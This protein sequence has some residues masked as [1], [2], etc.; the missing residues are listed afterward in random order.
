MDLTNKVKKQKVLNTG[1]ASSLVAAVTTSETNAATKP[2]A[3]GKIKVVAVFGTTDWNNGLGHEICIR[4]IF[5][6]KKDWQLI[7]VRANK[8]FTPQL[9]SDA[10]LL[11]TCRAG[12]ADPIDLF[13]K[14][15]GIA[16]TLVQG[17][18]L[19]TD[20]NVRAIIE[21]VRDRGMGLLALHNSVASD[22]KQFLDFLDVAV[23][24][25]HE[26]EPL[27]ATRI[28]KEHPITQGIG[29]F[30]ISNDE[31]YLV[32]IKSPSTATLFE[33]TAIHEKR[34]GVSGWALESGKGR[35]VGLLP[36]STVHAYQSPEYQNIVWRSAHWAMKR[37]I[38]P[39]PNAK[40]T[41]YD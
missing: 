6:S 31:Q 7:C 5:E 39:Y 33:T 30:L 37:D 36:G 38:Q 14:D 2:K 35:I 11:I 20:T 19:W 32:I 23:V 25:P 28:N 12:G 34:Q 22:N 16:D 15:G 21:N 24:T 41:Y 9:I 40:N 3:H 8:F 27:W 26:I 18:S 4:K 1:L 13:R 10:D 17:S 29:K